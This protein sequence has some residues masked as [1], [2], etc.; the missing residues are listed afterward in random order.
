MHPQ[1]T[2][3]CWAYNIG[4]PDNPSSYYSDDGEPSGTAGQP[5]LQSIKH[6]KLDNVVL[7]VVRYFGGIKLGVRGLIDTYRAAAQLAVAK[8]Q[9]IEEKAKTELPF[10]CSYQAYNTL[11]YKVE[12]ME[13]AIVSPAFGE[14]IEGVIVIPRAKKQELEN[15]IKDLTGYGA[16]K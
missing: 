8:C 6:E 13:G 3:V 7:A 5:I 2:H 11:L 12:Q 15:I 10:S 9:I 1:A 4:A 16:S 14:K